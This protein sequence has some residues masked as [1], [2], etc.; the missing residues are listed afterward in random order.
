MTTDIYG[1]GG[2]ILALCDNAPFMKYL[3]TVRGMAGAVKLIYADPPFYSG[4]AYQASVRIDPESRAAGSS[5]KAEAYDDK[6]NRNR[7][8]Y[9]RELTFRLMLMR[10]LLSDD[11]LI[12]VHLDWHAV[13]YVKVIMDEIFGEKNFVNEII[14]QYKSGGAGKKHFSKKH[15]TLLLYSKTKNYTMHPGKE[16]SYNREFKP[17]RFRNVRE[18]KDENGWYTMVTMK[19]VWQ[20]DM[21]GRTSGERTGYAT[22]KPE[23]LLRRIVESC[24]APGDICADFFCGCATLPAVCEKTGRKWI[25]CDSGALAVGISQKRLINADFALMRERDSRKAKPGKL[26][27][28]VSCETAGVTD[29]KL[30]RI[31]IKRYSPPM[32][33]LPVGKDDKSRV[34]EVRKDDSRK[35]IDFWSVDFDYDGDIHRPDL[36]FARAG[37]DIE[38][39]CER[40]IP[41]GR[42]VNVKVT[43]VFGCVTEEEI[44]YEE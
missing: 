41:D 19:D 16:K 17:Y 2:N 30:L 11:G 37:S 40:L 6:W 1:D 43:D 27:L 36:C 22:Q 21:V 10:D 26:T 23:A 8:S 29:M 25:A 7:Q 12:C 33:A 32:A 44:E 42:R 15:D 38:L 31:G 4:S 39:S 9:L 14:W 35:L 5:V 3:S 13:H 34:R 18:Y 24:S 28:D 20:I